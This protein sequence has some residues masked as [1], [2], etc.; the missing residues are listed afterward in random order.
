MKVAEIKERDERNFQ[1]VFSTDFYYVF[2]YE[3]RNPSHPSF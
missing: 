3:V 2:A 1:K